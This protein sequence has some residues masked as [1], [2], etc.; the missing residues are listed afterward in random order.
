M[1]FSKRLDYVLAKYSIIYSLA[2]MVYFVNMILSFV[3]S[4]VSLTAMSK[5]SPVVPITALGG[6]GMT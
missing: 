5:S 1:I 3:V 4:N 2:Y 6:V